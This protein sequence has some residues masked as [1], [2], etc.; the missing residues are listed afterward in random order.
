MIVT[1]AGIWMFAKASQKWNADSPICSTPQDMATL[2]IWSAVEKNNFSMTLTESGMAMLVKLLHVSK[3]FFE[4]LVNE[5]G[6]LNMLQSLA[7][8]K[9]RCANDNDRVRCNDT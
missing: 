7:A 2:S 1:D 5:R 6:S 8:Y 3:V 4:M 9:G